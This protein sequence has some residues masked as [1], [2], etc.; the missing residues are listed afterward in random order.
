MHQVFEPYGARGLVDDAPVEPTCQAVAGITACYLV[1]GQLVPLA[2]ELV[3]A[4]R[5]PVWP[6]Q[7]RLAASTVGDGLGGI[8]VED[9]LA[10][11][12]VLAQTAADLHRDNP[13]GAE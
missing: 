8:P 3:L 1:E 7:Q 9:S 10:I 6:G 2:T 12:A 5:Q 4:I 13:L 11:E